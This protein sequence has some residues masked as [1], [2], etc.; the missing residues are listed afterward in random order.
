MGASKPPKVNRIAAFTPI[1][2]R[3][4][5]RRSKVGRRLRSRSTSSIDRNLV[6]DLG[7]LPTTSYRSVVV[8]TKGDKVKVDFL[9]D[10]A[11]DVNIVS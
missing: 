3:I 1:K 6:V 10:D 7:A 4:I 2:R 5:V 9:L 8:V 11:A